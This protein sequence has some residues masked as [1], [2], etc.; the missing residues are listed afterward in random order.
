[1]GVQPFE[2]RPLPTPFRAEKHKKGWGFELWLCNLEIYCGKLLVFYGKRGRAQCSFH[3][4][5]DKDE[6]LYVLW[7]TFRF[8]L[9]NGDDVNS[10]T[11]LILKRGQ[12]LHIEPGLRHSMQVIGATG[13]GV[14]VEISTHHKDS[15]SIRIKKGD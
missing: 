13:L 10:A 9:S 1:M 3:Y 6:V 7:G 4:H 2:H 12:A 11:A 15:D 5:E 8:L 14:F